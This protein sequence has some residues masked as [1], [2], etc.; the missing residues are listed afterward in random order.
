MEQFIEFR[1]TVKTTSDE[2]VERIRFPYD[3][4]EEQAPTVE[5]AINGAIYLLQRHY[6]EERVN[7]IL[8]EHSRN[9]P[10]SKKAQKEQEPKE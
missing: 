3:A 2:I 7:K 5:Q 6:S 1:I 8:W 10:S 4:E 9:Y